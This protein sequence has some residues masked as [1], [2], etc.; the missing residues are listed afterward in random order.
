MPE[1]AKVTIR[2]GPYKSSDEVVE[3]RR[4]RLQ[5]LKAVLL[6]DGHQLV[7][8][9]TPDWNL[10]ELIVK[11]ENVFQCSITDLDFGGDGQLDPL[12]QEARAAVLN[13]Y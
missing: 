10:V 13:A 2:Y 7:F 5:G 11:G 4:F 9:E 6:A 12:C 1:N 8:E 3:H